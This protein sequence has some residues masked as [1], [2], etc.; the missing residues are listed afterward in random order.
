MLDET[1]FVRLVC[2]A[3]GD[4]REL[5]AR[6]EGLPHGIFRHCTTITVRSGHQHE[7]GTEYRNV[8]REPKS[9]FGFVV[10][11]TRW[12]NLVEH[13][14]RRRLIRRR[15]ETKTG[16]RDEGAAHATKHHAPTYRDQPRDRSRPANGVIREDS[17][18][19]S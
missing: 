3:T 11:G 9:K 6:R 19:R 1:L 15:N 16:N 8:A 4:D 14:A 7:H 10:V 13:L 5:V 2:E 18:T 12:G 17:R